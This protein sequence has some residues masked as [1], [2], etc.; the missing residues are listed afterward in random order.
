MSSVTTTSAASMAVCVA[1]RSPTSQCQMWLDFLSLSGRTSGELGSSALNG[2]MTGSSGSYSTWTRVM[3]SA[4]AYR[5]SAN[6]AATSW[7]WYTTWSVGSTIWVSLMSV[8]I[9]ASPAASRSLPVITATT[10]GAFNAS[11]VSMLLIVACAYGLRTM[12]M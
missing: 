10:P 11:E 9:H 6:T 3:A 1:A 4:A 12:S 2:S 7:A 8:G 5:V